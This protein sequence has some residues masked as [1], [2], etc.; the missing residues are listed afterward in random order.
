MFKITYHILKNLYVDKKK[1]ADDYVRYYW[2]IGDVKLDT[3]DSLI[4]M[5]WGSIPIVDFAI[6]FK[7][8]SKSLL[9]QK[10]GYK[11]FDFTESS[12]Y[13]ELYK[14]A[15]EI[16]IHPSFR[17]DII[18]TNFTEF[19]NEVDR[20]YNAVIEDIFHANSFLRQNEEFLRII[21]I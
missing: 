6:F 13:I 2:F 15:D 21:N 1:I 9:G 8:I 11:V 14:N 7:L 19:Y 16:E 4:D 5:S 3:N 20:F 10:N 12:E 18:I 17:A